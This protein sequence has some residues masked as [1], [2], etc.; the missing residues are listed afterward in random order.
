[1]ESK[2]RITS[3]Q[4]LKE[5]IN[6]LQLQHPQMARRTS[7]TTPVPATPT[8]RVR[9]HRKLHNRHRP[10]SRTT[11]PVVQLNETQGVFTSAP[12]TPESQRN[13]IVLQAESSTNPPI[14]HDQPTM[15]LATDPVGQNTSL[16]DLP[17][18][19]HTPPIIQHTPTDQNIPNDQFTPHTLS[20]HPPTDQHSSDQDTDSHHQDVLVDQHSVADQ[21]AN[22]HNQ[23]DEDTPTDQDTSIDQHIPNDQ[24]TP[25]DILLTDQHS[26]S[27]HDSENVTQP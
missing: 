24:H 19:E 9:P 4:E 22:H 15:R 7:S 21:D 26:S 16:T 1:M 11:S 10:F 25:T 23:T 5:Q 12:A 13:L 20:A 14:N 17:A 6:L 3:L 18:D 2:Q 27:D 8:T